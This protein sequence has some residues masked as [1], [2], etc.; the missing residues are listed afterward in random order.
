MYLLFNCT[1]AVWRFCSRLLHTAMSTSG[2][3]DIQ[4]P[5]V[6]ICFYIDVRGL[7]IGQVESDSD[8][9]Q[10]PRL[11]MVPVLHVRSEL[12]LRS[13]DLK[14][15]SQYFI[16]NRFRLEIST[17]EFVLLTP[18]HISSY[19]DPLTVV[20]LTYRDSLHFTLTKWEIPVNCHTLRFEACRKEDV[21]L[22]LC[23]WRPPSDNE[24]IERLAPR[25]PTFGSGACVDLLKRS[26]TCT[27]LCDTSPH[28]WH[29]FRSQSTH[30][31]LIFHLLWAI[32]ISTFPS[33]GTQHI[34]GTV[35]N[36][37]TIDMGYWIWPIQRTSQQNLMD[38][39]LKHCSFVR[40]PL[41]LWKAVGSQSWLETDVCMKA[42]EVSSCISVC[43]FLLVLGSIYIFYLIK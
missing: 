18:T 39:M 29:R 7:L 32:S 19:R 24:I 8:S 42:P 20:K 40:F 30:S 2:L 33:R 26:K 25:N 1:A 15:R 41:L 11:D 16:W 43:V 3:R 12:Q 34:T 27:L 4:T 38:V 37:A 13:D 14:K 5:V 23:R 10:D 35:S 6:R 22:T 9:D 36:E 28:Y 31:G 17:S 21:C